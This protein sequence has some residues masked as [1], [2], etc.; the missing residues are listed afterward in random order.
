MD[1][2]SL[3]AERKIVEAMQEGAF[4]HLEGTGEP[5]CLDEN[6]YEDP[7]Q[8]MAHRVLKNNGFAPDWILEAKELDAE[9]RRM[10]A[11]GGAPDRAARVAGLNRRIAVYNLKVPI[12]GAQKL[13]IE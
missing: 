5:L 8:R 11:E 1:V 6:P 10:R 4:D 9:I 3:V 13:L 12:A 7:S 2:W